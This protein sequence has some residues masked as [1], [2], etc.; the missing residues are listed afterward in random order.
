MSVRRTE[1]DVASF[2]RAS[3]GGVGVLD[4]PANSPGRHKDHPTV[5]VRVIAELV[6]FRHDLSCFRRIGRR[7]PAGNEEGSSCAALPQNA[8]YIL[9]V[10]ACGTIVER[11]GDDGVRRLDPRH[12]LSKELK[13]ARLADA[14]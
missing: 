12:Y 9:R 5:R 7:F 2:S 1:V 13:I 3:D 8:E 4:L 6:P 14:P 10:P 11:Q